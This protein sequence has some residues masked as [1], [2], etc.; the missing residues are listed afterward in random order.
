[1]GVGFDN[2]GELST[3][4]GYVFD[5]NGNP[6]QTSFDK[7]GD[8]KDAFDKH[9][10]RFSTN[11]GVFDKRGKQLCTKHFRQMCMFCNRYFFGSSAHSSRQICMLFSTNMQVVLCNKVI[12]NEKYLRKNLDDR[13]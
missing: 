5:I 13:K 8:I 3:D 1:M 11:R 10:K 7:C 9:G 12:F 6:F 2:Q 4:A